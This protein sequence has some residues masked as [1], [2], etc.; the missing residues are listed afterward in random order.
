MG[1]QPPSVT[2]EVRLEA[3]ATVQDTT[4]ATISPCKS[5]QRTCRRRAAIKR[6]LSGMS[7]LPRCHLLGARWAEVLLNR[8]L[9][10]TG[11]EED[12][13]ISDDSDDEPPTKSQ[14]RVSKARAT[15][16]ASAQMPTLP[17]LGYA[18]SPSQQST[19]GP[20]FIKKRSSRSATSSAF[21]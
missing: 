18:S 15:S 2:F 11:D 14:Q 7:R 10:A 16:T 9:F 21:R 12:V 8:L 20:A 4:E 3:P 6:P 19:M 1:K 17:L 13:K 5:L